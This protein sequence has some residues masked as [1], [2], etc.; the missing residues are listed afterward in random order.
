M[1]KSKTPNDSPMNL[2]FSISYTTPKSSPVKTHYYYCWYIK[3]YKPKLWQQG[4]FSPQHKYFNQCPQL[5]WFSQ[6]ARREKK[7]VGS[8]STSFQRIHCKTQL[9]ILIQG[10]DWL[11]VKKRVKDEYKTLIESSWKYLQHIAINSIKRPFFSPPPKR[12]S[13]TTETAA[14]T[15]PVLQ[16]SAIF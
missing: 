6:W 8:G 5:F 3:N 4:L 12:Y 2:R 15:S 7:W 10:T 9:T 16:W 14:I 1:G 11:P 13:S